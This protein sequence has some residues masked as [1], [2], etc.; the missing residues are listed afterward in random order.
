MVLAQFAQG[1]FAARK[2]SALAHHARVALEP[3]AKAAALGIFGQQDTGLL[4]ALTD[5]GHMMVQTAGWQVQLAAGLMVAQAHAQIAALGITGVHQAP[6]EN[7]GA[8]V[9][10][11]FFGAPQHQHFGALV[12]LAQHDQRGCTADW[13]W[14]RIGGHAVSVSK[15][16][17]PGWGRA[18][19]SRP[20]VSQVGLRLRRQRAIAACPG[21]AGPARCRPGI[22]RAGVVA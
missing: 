3:A 16:F 5:G 7:P 11:A 17:R 10:V 13:G 12:T 9:L 22:D 6:G 21:P 4:E 20:I 19:L 14:R 1:D 8:A 18:K 15:T 2:L